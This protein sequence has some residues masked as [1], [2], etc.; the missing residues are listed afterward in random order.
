MIIHKKPILATYA[1]KALK[2]LLANDRFDKEQ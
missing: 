2:S 1:I